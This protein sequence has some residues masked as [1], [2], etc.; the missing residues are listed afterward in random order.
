M[1]LP[2]L[3]LPAILAT[4]VLQAPPA[5]PVE[6]P[7]SHCG[8]ADAAVP[9]CCIHLASWQREA[10]LTPRHEPDP[11]RDQAD[12]RIEVDVAQR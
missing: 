7:S 6:A 8:R 1:S 3:E 11:R 9:D 12:S 2:I 10:R 5:P 4:L